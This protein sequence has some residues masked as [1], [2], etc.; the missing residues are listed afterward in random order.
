MI[1]CPPILFLTLCMFCIFCMLCVHVRDVADVQVPRDFGFPSNQGCGLN[2]GLTLR[3]GCHCDEYHM[4]SGWNQH[5]GD[6]DTAG[7]PKC[8]AHQYCFCSGGPRNA[9][10]DRCIRIHRLRHEGLEIWVTGDKIC[11]AVNE[12]IGRR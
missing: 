12:P 1:H 4:Y 9:D 10:C 6:E 2:H 7:L 11:Q 5:Y 3:L 8:E